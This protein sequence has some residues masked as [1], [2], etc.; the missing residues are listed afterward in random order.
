MES[1]LYNVTFLI[2]CMCCGYVWIIHSV[3]ISCNMSA[4]YLR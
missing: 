4:S 3:D 1:A 2:K